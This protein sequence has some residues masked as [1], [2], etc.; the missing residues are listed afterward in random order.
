MQELLLVTHCAP[1][2]AGL[3]TGNLFTCH[4][5]EKEQLFE[6]VMGWNQMFERKGLYVQMLKAEAGRALIYVYRRHRLE[7]DLAEERV[8]EFLQEHGYPCKA[9]EE[10]RIAAMLECLAERICGNEEFPHEI[11]L[12]LGYPFEDVKGFIENRGQ[13]CKCVGCWKVY[14]DECA[15]QKLFA[16]YQWCTRIYCRKFREGTPIQKLVVTA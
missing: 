6:V 4:Y 5:T 12:F 7:Q 3:K 10:E 15:A 11:G 14:T 8:Q 2:L 13:N 1:T 9:A 16:K